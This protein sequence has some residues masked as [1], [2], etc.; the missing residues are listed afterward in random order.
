MS[1]FKVF[2]FMQLMLV[3]V[4]CQTYPMQKQ[5]NSSWG[6]QQYGYS[7]WTICQ[8][9]S[10]LS[11]IS[12]ALTGIGNNYNPGTLNNWLKQNDGYYSGVILLRSINRLGLTFKGRIPN[13]HVKEALDQGH[14]VICAIDK[15]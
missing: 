2:V 7:S 6:S 1:L 5:C 15:D 13:S 10:A 8:K 11:S 14:I 3:L 4:S 12:M 9:G